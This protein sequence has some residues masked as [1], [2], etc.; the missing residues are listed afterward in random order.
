MIIYLFL[1][2][3]NRQ[4]CNKT[5]IILEKALRNDELRDYSKIL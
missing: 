1:I 5:F 3:K 2:A 4:H